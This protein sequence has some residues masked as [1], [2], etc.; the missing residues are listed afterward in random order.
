MTKSSM[1]MFQWQGRRT[2]GR[3]ENI[4]VVTLIMEVRERQ[5][6]RFYGMS[7]IFRVATNASDGTGPAGAD[8]DRR[9]G[10]RE[11]GRHADVIELRGDPGPGVGLDGDGGVRHGGRLG[12]GRDGVCDGSRGGRTRLHLDERHAHVRPGRGRSDRDGDGLRRQGVR[13]R[14]AVVPPALEPFERG[15]RRESRSEPG[16]RP[17]SQHRELDRDLDRRGLG[18][19]RRGR[20]SGVHAHPRR[21]RGGRSDGAGVR[22]RRRGDAG[23]GGA[24]ER[25]VRAGRAGGGAEGAD[26]RRR[27]RTRRTAR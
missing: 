10:A 6:L 23:D 5:K 7:P 27:G 9:G 18:L 15:D 24:G 2:G 17:D 12:H 14:R 4:L 16:R 1:L 25:L 13:Q 26:R 3:L 11:R 21:R 8:G 20:R 22:H 19:C